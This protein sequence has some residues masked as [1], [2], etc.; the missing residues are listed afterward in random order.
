MA[1]VAL[2]AVRC[3]RARRRAD[4]LRLMHLTY[5]SLAKSLSI[6]PT[7]E[8]VLFETVIMVEPIQDL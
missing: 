3:Y 6:I 1:K 4:I 8:F 7:G 2:F 5:S